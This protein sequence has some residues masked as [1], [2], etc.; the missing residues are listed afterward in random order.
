[1]SVIRQKLLFFLPTIFTLLHGG[2][3]FFGSWDFSSPTV[4]PLQS[5]VS[6]FNDVVYDL[7]SKSCKRELTPFHFD[8]PINPK[9]LLATH[10]SGNRIR[11]QFFDKM[12]IPSLRHTP[13]KTSR[14]AWTEYDFALFN[15][16]YHLIGPKILPP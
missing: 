4:T 13:I 16:A 14:R 12:Q 2:L 7:R 5:P 10:F 8:S 9:R 6:L 11:S 3:N 1:M 15:S